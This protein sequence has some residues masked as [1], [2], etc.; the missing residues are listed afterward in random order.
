MKVKI[1]Q[2]SKKGRKG[3]IVEQSTDGIIVSLDRKREKNY[4]HHKTEYYVFV[5][6]GAYERQKG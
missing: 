4:K 6:E 3:T 2:G 1:T 5:E